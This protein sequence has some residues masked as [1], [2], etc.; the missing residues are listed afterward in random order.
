MKNEIVLEEKRYPYAEA[1]SI[2]LAVLEELRPHC[3]RIEIAG[4]IRRKKKSIGDIEIVAIPKP[5]ITGATESGLALVVNKWQKAKG[6]MEYGKTK[7]TQRIL[8]EGIKLDLFFADETNW[9]L[10]FAM[11]TGSADF[12][13][14]VLADGWSRRGFKSVGGYITRDGEKIDVREE[15]DLFRIAGVLYKEP[16]ERNLELAK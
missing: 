11:R 12:S 8:P 3:S 4:S 5:Y 16:E 13:H 15:I 2:A 1:Y 10:I 14:K 7:Y 9:G 6:N